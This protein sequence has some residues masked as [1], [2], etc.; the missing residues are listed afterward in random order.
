[1]TLEHLKKKGKLN[2]HN[3]PMNPPK[4]VFEKRGCSK[5]TS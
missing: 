1:M 3:C 2:K 5:I 4:I